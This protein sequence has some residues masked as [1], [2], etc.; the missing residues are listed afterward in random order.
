M[1]LTLH[2]ANEALRV[3]FANMER[4]G[5]ESRLELGQTFEQAIPAKA[6]VREVGLYLRQVPGV[7]PSFPSVMHSSVQNST[8]QHC[9]V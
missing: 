1:A 7:S 5:P 9:S 6:A 4:E 2:S 3:A 8:E